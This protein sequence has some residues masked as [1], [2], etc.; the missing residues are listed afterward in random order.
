MTPH[1]MRVAHNPPGSYGDCYRTCIACVLDVDPEEVPHP[2]REGG[3]RWDALTAEVDRWLADRNLYI[4]QLKDKPEVFERHCDYFG[5][6]LIAGQSPRGGHYCVGLGGK[7][8]HNPSPFG[9]GLEPDEDGT[10]TIM[11][12]VAGAKRP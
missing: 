8:V 11:L 1:M 4:V 9:D 10:Y 2:G 3:E 6:H 12:L 5:Y 7:V